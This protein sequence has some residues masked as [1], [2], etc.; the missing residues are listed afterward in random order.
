MNKNKRLLLVTT[1]LEGTWGKSQDIL[2]LGEWCK[3]FSRRHVWGKRNSITQTA[4]WSDRAKLAN[5]YEYI[6]ELY[7]RILAP[8]AIAVLGFFSCSHVYFTPRVSFPPVHFGTT[9]VS[10]H[11]LA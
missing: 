1:A 4:D 11:A 5:D 10:P 8:A 6:S 7:E 9:C 3:K 2:F